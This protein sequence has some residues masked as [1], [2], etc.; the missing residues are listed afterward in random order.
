MLPW[1]EHICHPVALDLHEQQNTSA[2]DGLVLRALR[3]S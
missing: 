2:V 1:S 3:Q